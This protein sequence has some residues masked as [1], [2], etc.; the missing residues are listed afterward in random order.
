MTQAFTPE[1]QEAVWVA[2]NKAWA[3]YNGHG[4]ARQASARVF[5]Q[6]LGTLGDAIL[7]N[8]PIE[9]SIVAA[10]ADAKG[11]ADVLR[12]DTE[13]VNKAWLAL[14]AIVVVAA[15]RY[16]YDVFIQK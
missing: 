6:R 11:I 13:A 10:L 14:Q 9:A 7:G 12:E 8:P 5:T 4:N 3:A 15:L 16:G 2:L 1:Q